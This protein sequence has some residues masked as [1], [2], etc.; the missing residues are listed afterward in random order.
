MEGKHLNLQQVVFWDETHKKVHIGKGSK[1]VKLEV[2]FPRDNNNKIN[3]VKGMYAKRSTYL[4]VKY[5]E[6]VHLLLRVVQVKIG[7]NFVDKR[8]VPFDYLAKVLLSISDHE[9]YIEK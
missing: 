4:Q 5:P 2:R 8:A 6:E 3:L 1:T 7:E 9:M